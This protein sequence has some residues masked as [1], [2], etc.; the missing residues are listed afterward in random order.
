MN[1]KVEWLRHYAHFQGRVQQLVAEDIVEHGTPHVER[2]ESFHDLK[3]RC[4]EMAATAF[5]LYTAICRIEA[6][7]GAVLLEAALNANDE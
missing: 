1:D 3:G 7:A 4:A 6:D 5:E 2:H